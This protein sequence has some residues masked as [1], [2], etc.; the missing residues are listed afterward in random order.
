[1]TT[2]EANFV[3]SPSSPPVQA[4][5]ALR[6]RSLLATGVGN[7]LEWFD[8]AVY[9]VFSTYIAMALFNQD[10]PV[11]A[12][13]A[14]LAV[15]AVGF[16][17]RPLGGFV[18]GRIADR[19]GRKW[20]LLVTM[21]MMAFGSLLI[22]LI[23]SYETIGGF[24]SILFLFAR[25]IQGFAHGGESTTSNVYL[26]EIAPPHRR[27]LY[28]ST[29]ALAMGMGTMIATMFG[30]VLANTFTSEVMNEWG[31]RI[32]FI[33]GGF[34]ALVVLWLR[35]NM[36][37]S[38]VLE[39]HVATVTKSET[40]ATSE[41]L[42]KASALGEPHVHASTEAHVEVVWSPRKIFV[43]AVEVF[44][45][46]AGTTLPYYIWSAFAATYA[47][48]Q[49]S[50]DPGGAFT[51]SL[52]AMAVNLA[53]VPVMG[54]AADRIGRRIPVLVYALATAAL[55]VPVFAMIDDN[56]W[57]LFLAQSLMMGL[58]ACIGGTQPAMLSE[59]IPTRYRTLIM[60]T[61]MPL[62]VALFGGTAPYVN[63]WLAS[64]DMFWLF[65]AYI[66]AMTLGTAFVV[67]F[68]W[69]ETKGIRL[70]DVR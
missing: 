53:L 57:T 37:E 20:V 24:A 30:S 12:L 27:A 55:T 52:G 28:G 42:E 51:A 67:A 68:R 19:K 26:P 17:M 3:L 23:P 31:W 59:Q 56:P 18:F 58:S 48:N 33:F 50:M 4:S 40:A 63:T 43:K 1:M 54:L 36:M 66:I 35:R 60:G 11:S 39:A 2:T 62:A 6:R 41:D 16:V 49:K 34:L 13:L 15:F 46:M 25:L 21:L 65:D 47:I 61:A 22:G 38:E 32:P 10:N 8:W 7:V 69:K 29:I 14:T 44:F 45:Y 70:T 64:K 5:N 9:G